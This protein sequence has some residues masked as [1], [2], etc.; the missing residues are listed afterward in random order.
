MNELE[1]RYTTPEFT[2]TVAGFVYKWPGL[3]CQSNYSG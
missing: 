1:K 3:I 2:E